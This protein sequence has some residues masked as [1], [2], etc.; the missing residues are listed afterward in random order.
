MDVLPSSGKRS[1]NRRV[2]IPALSTYF[3]SAPRPACANPFSNPDIR[4]RALQDLEFYEQ[5]HIL[6]TDCAKIGGV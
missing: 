3:V 5:K 6:V 4:P 1:P 2:Y